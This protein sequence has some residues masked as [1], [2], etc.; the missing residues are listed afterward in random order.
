MLLSPIVLRE[1]Q[2]LSYDG[3]DPFMYDSP[4]SGCRAA[5]CWRGACDAFMYFENRRLEEC[6]H[7]VQIVANLHVPQN[8]PV[9]FGLRNYMIREKHQ[10]KLYSKS[11]SDAH[12]RW[13]NCTTL[14]YLLIVAL[15]VFSWKFKKRESCR[16]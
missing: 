6:T 15:S 16:S 7:A 10:I 5:T 14:R 4:L 2:R 11:K 8:R 13:P 9:G 3:D 12:K 1:I